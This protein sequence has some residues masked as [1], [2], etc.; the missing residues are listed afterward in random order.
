MTL[1]KAT[2]TPQ[3]QSLGVMEG[4]DLLARALGCE[5]AALLRDTE[6]IVHGTTVATNALLERKGARVGLLT[7]AG[8]RDVI[9]MREGLKDD[10]Y[11]LRM[12]P[13]G[14]ARAARA[15][16]RRSGADAR[17]RACR[18]AA[19]RALPRPGHRRPSPRAASRRWRSAISTPIVTT[20]HERATERA[21][22]PGAA[23]RLRVPLLR[24]AAA[25]QGVRARL[26]DRRQ[27]LRRPGAVALSLAPGASG[28]ST[29]A[30]R[31]PVLI[32]QSHGGVVPIADAVRIAAG[33]VLSGPAG[34]VA[35]SRYCARLLGEGNLIPFDMGGTS[36]DIS[37]VENGR[38]QPL[39]RIGA[40]PGH[41]V[42]LPSLDIVRLGA[43]GG[44]IAWVDP[45]GI[46][47]SDPRARAPSRAL[48]ATARAARPPP[49]PTRIS[50][51]ATSIRA[52]SSAAARG[53]TLAAAQRAL[54]ALAEP[55]RHRSVA[56]AEGIH[57]SST[58]AWPRA[59]ASSRC[60]AASIRGGSRCWPSAGPP[61]CT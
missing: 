34:G 42:A 20:R 1:A 58:R 14:A 60:G 49:S 47:R 17:R 40:S 33:A 18:D 8:H 55:A 7:T 2:S 54:D 31:G 4:L 28:W 51:S 39:D 29:R 30:T 57:R 26:H 38:G 41:H 45:G 6:R 56:A 10:R 37:L 25:D 5:R 27:C 24:G 21:L 15:A 53:S 61:A 19:R 44:S 11:N 13:P 35:G 43:G 23:G 12:P 52:T 50:C 16:A 59:S 22:R 3:D 9:E 32:I 46:L 36:T 48:R